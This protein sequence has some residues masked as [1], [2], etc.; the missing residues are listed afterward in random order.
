[1]KLEKEQLKK[2]EEEEEYKRKL[3]GN[4]R[5][6]EKNGFITSRKNG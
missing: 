1:M 4:W 6:W 5:I 2:R 3:I